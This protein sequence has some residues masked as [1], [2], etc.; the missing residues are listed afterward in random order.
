MHLLPWQY[1]PAWQTPN[2]R[3]TIR[4][5]RFALADLLADSLSLCNE[6]AT[7]LLAA[8]QRVQL[9]AANETRL[10]EATF[11]EVC[12]WTFAQ[13]LADVF[14]PDRVTE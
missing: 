2:W 13:V 3:Y 11:P 7:V 10:P 9:R 5:Q 12:P 14:R 8:Y 1:Q 6:G 4:Y